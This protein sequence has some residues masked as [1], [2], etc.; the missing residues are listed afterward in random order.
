MTK[1]QGRSR[2]A[3]VLGA[4]A[5]MAEALQRRTGYRPSTAALA[6]AVLLPLAACGTGGTSA[7]IL[8]YNGQHPQLTD[9]LVQAFEKQTGIHVSERTNDG[10]VLADQIL[11]EGRSSPADVYV[12][13]N[14]PELAT[15]EQRGLLA[16][17]ASTT[18]KQVPAQYDSPTG[19]WVGMALRVSALA[20]D[21]ELEPAADLPTS[22]LQLA[23]PRWR[24]RVAIA[25]TDSD[26]PPLVGA[27]IA[28]H[29]ATAARDWLDGLKRNAVIYQD[30]EAVLSAVN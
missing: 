20:Y 26:F 16:P 21:P 28:T 25:P 3:R 19:R 5:R 23:Q 7:S 4:W 30:D 2:R 15:L 24:G 11:Q 9:A 27:V 18:L 13:E 12:T 1:D 29:G 14:S 22:I 10:I 8:L 6:A 17:L